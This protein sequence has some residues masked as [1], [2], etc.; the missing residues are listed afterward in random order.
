MRLPK[1]HALAA[2]ATLAAAPCSA[3][4]QTATVT[5]H[6]RTALSIGGVTAFDRTQFI[7]LHGSPT[8]P[9]TS[10]EQFRYLTEEL[11]V[12]WGRDGGV[13]TW[14]MGRTPAD[15]DH[16]GM[17][18]LAALAEAGRRARAEAAANPRHDPELMRD[19][20][21]CTH[22][23]FMVGIPGNDFTAWGPRTP[24]AAAAWVSTFLAEFYTDADR[25]RLYEVFNEPFVHAAEIGTTRRQMAEQHVVT[26][27]A[28]RERTPGVLVGGYSAAWAEVEA[29]GFGQW[30]ANQK[31]F[32]DV[33]GAEM[34][35]FSTHLYDGINIEG[36]H[37]ERTG[38]NTEAILDLIDQYSH[39]RF[40]VAKPQTITEYGRIL[41]SRNGR[42]WPER[43]RRE[44]LILRSMI[45]MNHTFMDH[46]DR[47]LKAIP[48]ILGVGDWTYGLGDN[49]EEEPYDYLLFRRNG[50]ADHHVPT[51][52]EHFY[53][54][55]KGVEGDWRSHSS[56]DPDVRVHVLAD[57]R[58]LSLVLTNL[59]D[60]AHAVALRGLDGLDVGRVTLR[61]LTTDGGFPQLTE[62]ALPAVPAAI[63]LAVGGSALL[64]ID[65]RVDLAVEATLQRRRTYATDYLQPIAAGEPVGFTFQGTPTGPGG[66]ARLRL[67]IARDPA[68]SLSPELSVNGERV[69]FPE[70]W[71]GGDQAG[72]PT[73]YG[74]IPVDVPSGLLR[75]TT[76]VRLVFPDSG[77]HVAAAVLETTLPR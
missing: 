48:F 26:A 23:Q 49:T 3:T 4:A 19:V 27:R 6:P 5:V 22:P 7:T 52:L 38:S 20:V 9:D 12:A 24:E 62:R 54:F 37:T 73:F 72:R 21:L 35:F 77:G 33:A 13:Q 68:L 17:P 60:A 31:M 53:R 40:G 66:N 42:A 30:H 69:P 47:I 75:D 29:A 71:M 61:S 51:G 25:P 16:A 43:G 50:G 15:P 74:M 1:I 57:G 28:I 44:A 14:R 45:G 2:A 32:M 59:D 64:T 41:F 70:D 63:D 56:T 10:D 58:R 8:D 18:D 36:T 39:L 11:G 76:H 67:S 65:S 34:D 55:W 46:P